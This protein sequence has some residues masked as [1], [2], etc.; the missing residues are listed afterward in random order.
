[1]HG[2]GRVTTSGRG[3]WTRLAYRLRAKDGFDLTLHSKLHAFVRTLR[4]T[5]GRPL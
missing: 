3:A 2:R 4:G 1:M 5:R